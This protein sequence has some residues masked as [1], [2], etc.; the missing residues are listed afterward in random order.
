MGAA[1]AYSAYRRSEI[2]TLSP[3]DLLVKMFEC[4]DRLDEQAAM[5]MQNGQI[6][7][8]TRAC[9]R[10]RDIV[11]ELQ[12]T[13]NFEVGGEI[14]DRLDALYRF[15]I[16]EITEANLRKDAKRLR[17]LQRV[18]RPLLEGWKG[19]PDAH[20]HTTSLTGDGRD[21]VINMRG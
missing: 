19:V 6:E 14:A 15:L 10:M 16:V 1:V 12:A 21:N 18:I 8:S 11:F 13:L 20:S 4:L 5:A 7:L 9:Q 3:R 17:Q 2:E